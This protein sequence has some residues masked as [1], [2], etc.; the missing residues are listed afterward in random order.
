MPWTDDALDKMLHESA[1]EAES[2]AE[3]VD[4]DAST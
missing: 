2:A 4:Y 3:D 1:G